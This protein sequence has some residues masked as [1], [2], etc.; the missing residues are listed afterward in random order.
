MKTKILVMIISFIFLFTYN[1]QCFAV[2]DNLEI[3]NEEIEDETKTEET[4]DSIE[5][6]LEE[7]N[8]NEMIDTEDNII[9]EETIVDEVNIGVTNY[10]GMLC[11]DSPTENQSFNTRTAGNILSIAGW[12][13]SNDSNAKL[14]CL[15]DDNI[16]NQK[17]ERVSRTDVD[18]LISPGFGGALTT[19][20]A[21]FN[22]LVDI[23]LIK[24][25]IHKLKIRELSFDNQLICE[26]EISLNIENQPYIRKHVY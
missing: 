18:E 26:N 24:T 13:V 11:I 15:L 21:G 7:T 16:V 19:P 1:I 2:T 4:N 17:F 10:S 9:E 5:E 8:I 6:C 3:V 23:S 22:C 25:G 12:A 14:Q 20:N